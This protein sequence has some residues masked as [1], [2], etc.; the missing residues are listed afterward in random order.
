MRI[1]LRPQRGVLCVKF[2]WADLLTGT[3]RIPHET[4]RLLETSS[5][6]CLY[7]F[8]MSTPWYRCSMLCDGGHLWIWLIFFNRNCRFK[9]RWFSIKKKYQADGWKFFSANHVSVTFSNLIIPRGELKAKN[10]GFATTWPSCGR[11]KI[12]HCLPPNP[13]PPLGTLKL[14]FLVSKSKQ[15]LFIYF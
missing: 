1:Q 5:S 13:T 4:Q 2:R 6:L 11:K 9:N 3:S 15:L 14:L 8:T 12:H 7:E 10:S